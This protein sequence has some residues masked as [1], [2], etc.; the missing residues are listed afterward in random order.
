MI[1]N[2]AA[3]A[4]Q[5]A[6]LLLV[7]VGYAVVVPRLMGPA[8]YGRF[9]LLISVMTWFY[10]LSDL[11]MP[12]AFSRRV[13]ERWTGGVSGELRD[14]LGQVLALRAISA[15]ICGA[16]FAGAA[17][18]FLRDIDWTLIVPFALV[19]L[20][21][22]LVEPLFSWQLGVN[23]A[24]RWGLQF[25]VRR[26]LYLCCVPAGFV[27]GG[28]PGAAAGIVL[29]EIVVLGLGLALTGRH[30]AA[31]G[32]RL[33]TEILRP[34]L[35]AGLFFFA[36]NL[37]S[38]TFRYSG[39]AL[40]TWVTRDYVQVGFFGL[41]MSVYMAAEAGFIQA[42][43]AVTPYLGRLQETGQAENLGRW[44]ERLLCALT[45]LAMPAVFAAW[46]LADEIAPRFF[47]EAFRPAAP[48]LYLVGFALLAGIAQGTGQMMSI[49]LKKPRIYLAASAV[50]LAVF[51]VGG[52]LLTRLWGSFGA[53][54]ALLL[55]PAA[56]ALV[57]LTQVRGEQPFSPRRWWTALALAA[58]FFALRGVG[59]DILMFA[60][61]V[62]GYGFALFATRT[63]RRGELVEAWRAVFRKEGSAT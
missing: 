6:A 11:G 44:I 60:A 38:S 2:A 40:V 3:L 54:A 57:G 45:A 56:S 4:V 5:R 14:L 15:V 32:L 53:C 30:I 10:I 19:V 16:L 48:N 51:V 26:T 27:L 61:A 23:R 37:I 7:G 18:L 42:L 9:T 17:R 49:V 20:I 22:G 36:G 21:D 59:P 39:E 8:D 58:P 29:S 46:F 1:R 62:A 24:E 33:R 55:A 31:G 35:G 43:V 25:L 28:L 13:T 41:S 47:G 34:L 52:V 12:Q 63:I 50:R